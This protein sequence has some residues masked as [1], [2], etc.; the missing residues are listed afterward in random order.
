[1][2]GAE[3]IAFVKGVVTWGNGRGIPAF[4][5]KFFARLFHSIVSRF[6]KSWLKIP[7]LDLVRLPRSEACTLLPRKDMMNLE[8]LQ[9]TQPASVAQGERGHS[10]E[11]TP[12][13]IQGEGSFEDE[14]TESLRT[15]ADF[16]T[17]I[18]LYTYSPVKPTKT[19]S[20]KMSSDPDDPVAPNRSKRGADSASLSTSTRSKRR[21][22]STSASAS[23]SPAPSTVLT[24]SAK[25]GSSRKAVRSKDPYSPVN[26]LVDSIR[27][28]LMLLMIGLNPGL[29]TAETG[30]A[31]AHPSNH[32]WKLMHSSGLTDRRHLPSET[33]SLMDLYSIGNTNLC[34]RPTRDGAGLSKDELEAGV[35]VLEEKVRAY[36]PEVVCIVGKGIWETIVKV[37]V[38][39]GAKKQAKDVFNYGWQDERLWL[40]REVDGDGEVVW[41]G[42]RTFVATTT[43]GLAASTK[44]AEKAA[45]WKELGDWIVAKRAEDMVKA[46]EDAGADAEDVVTEVVP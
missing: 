18:G 20:E 40:G 41:G 42:A 14:S 29:K 33:R 9:M 26:N 37:K 28:G 21:A 38:R 24:K 43:S 2:Y 11:A 12:D 34:V 7:A 16:K 6:P 19:S 8:H 36:R 44:P 25:R 39:N 46:E 45:I 3:A 31:Y 35:P 4:G 13:H 22:T 23:A 32:F 1:M 17:R 15:Q 10:R 27:P 30:H 5:K